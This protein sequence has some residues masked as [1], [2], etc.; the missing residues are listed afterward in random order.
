MFEIWLVTNPH[1]TIRQ[2]LD[3]LKKEVTKENTIVHDYEETLKMSCSSSGEL[4]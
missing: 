3:A 1:T 2:V 4:K